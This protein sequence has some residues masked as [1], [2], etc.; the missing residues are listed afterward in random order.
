MI[1]K[2]LKVNNI[3]S[4]KDLTL[5]FPTTTQLF[6]GD[7]GSGK[8]SVL[9]AIEFALFGTMG[10]LPGDSL[11][12][13][14]QKKGFAELTF[15]IDSETYTI[16]RGL[17]TVI[18]N[19][20]EK[21]TQPEGWFIESGS[22]ATYTTTELRIKIL[23]LL[24]Y[25]LSKYKSSSKKCIDIYRYTVY[26]PQEEIKAIL[27]A[28][29][30]ER[31]EILK[32]VLEIEKYENTKF[33]LEKVLKRLKAEFR[34]IEEKIKSIG[35]P[36]EDIPVM[37]QNITEQQKKISQKKEEIG[38]YKKLLNQE[39]EKLEQI[40]KG[41][42]NYSKDISKL[43][44]NQEKVQEDEISIKKN[45]DK[46]KKLDLEISNKQKELNSL[47]TIELKTNKT[48]EELETEI[49]KFQEEER[50]VKDN[51]VRV[52]KK[53]QDVEKLLEE[54][55]CS[56]CG[57]KIHEKE[58]FDAELQQ[59]KEKLKKFED[60]LKKLESQI[61]DLKE[62][63]KNVRKFEKFT[64]KKA[65]IEEV[66]K[67]KQNHKKDLI[68]F[69]KRTKE[70]IES[71]KKEIKD[72][73]HTHKMDSLKQFEEYEQSVK[74]KL[75]TQKNIINEM[76]D[77]K[78]QME[79]DLSTFESELNTLKDDFKS[80]KE[81]V[82]LKQSLKGKYKYINIIT[83]WVAEQL[84][85]LI[86]DIERTILSS[87]AFQFN[88]Y[89]KEWFRALVEDENIDININSENFQP[90]VKIDG[91]ESPFQDLSGGE[92]SALSLA[93]RLALNKIINTKYQDNK[94]KDLLILDE[95]TDGFS[96]QQVN[97][98]QDVFDKLNTRQMIIISHER[99]LDS[100]VTDIFNFRKEA[101]K[102]KVIKEE[103]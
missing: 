51:T 71:T 67:G 14:G 3:R 26:T 7:I 49:K 39:K 97:K 37:E 92:K 85:K 4:I 19:E 33:N 50:N 91:Y 59:T 73:L 44:S 36:E 53:I 65:N 84:P 8:S 64:E 38:E 57:Q 94:T 40:E 47:P 15:T 72:V 70:K 35:T 25:S 98:M 62:L 1:L 82:T 60:N 5:E 17:K 10:D 16:H 101:H 24:N 52:E 96:E 41:Y 76:Q 56:L 63:Q 100:F 13:R 34:R 45:E 86:E 42:L 6:Y 95:P 80:L 79:K 43:H 74:T 11:L 22:K 12:R 21:I 29:P 30:K 23:E 31:F 99:N 54:G 55:K 61:E 90:I 2:S 102:T 87:T 89:F 27:L 103:V 28:D 78:T 81:M 75:A 83:D 93:Y 69:N 20:E 46:L 58:R 77:A 48:E 9:K 88:L 68:E 32:D 18:R 66:L